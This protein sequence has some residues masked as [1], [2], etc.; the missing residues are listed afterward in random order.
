MPADTDV[1]VAFSR[2]EGGVATLMR[3]TSTMQRMNMPQLVMYTTDGPATYRK[4]PSAGPTMIAT[5]VADAD[6]ATARGN[7]DG[8]IKVGSMADIVGLLNAL[9]APITKTIAKIAS[10]FSQPPML[11]AA[12]RPAAMASTRILK[13]AT[14]RRS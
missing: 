14:W 7:R 8:G 3:D 1:S 12:R 5:C 13:R 9:P 2:V 10:L 4:P 6:P 11:P